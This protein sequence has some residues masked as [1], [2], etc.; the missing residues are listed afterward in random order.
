MDELW[1]ALSREAALASEHLAIGVTALGKADFS[2]HA[3]YGQAFFALTTGIER[4][5]KLSII[6]DKFLDS[7]NFPSNNEIRHYGH[8]IKELLNNM[9]E[10]AIRCKF[11]DSWSRLPRSKIHNQIIQIL[12]DFAN[13]VTRYYN[14][15]IIVGNSNQRSCDN[16]VSQWYNQVVLS[17]IEEHSLGSRIEKY[18]FEAKKIDEL[19]GDNF[20][21]RYHDETGNVI[22]S[23]NEVIIQ[24]KITEITTPYA[25]LYVMQIIRFMASIQTEL[26]YLAIGKREERIPMMSDFF[27]IYMNEDNYF[28][29]R[30]TWSIY[31][32]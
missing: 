27:K 2:Q 32:L 31:K 22:N 29:R 23:L 17:I 19:I 20:Y 18:I 11:F 21:I 4:T 28:K 3:Y 7:G 9:D 30:K 14:I 25:R 26:T 24:K 8:N 16:P 1:Q 13:N 10:I 5:A 12:S 6:I 15:D